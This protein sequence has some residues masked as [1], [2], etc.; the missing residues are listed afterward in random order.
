MCII[1][2]LRANDLLEEARAARGTRTK[3]IAYPSD[4]A[5]NSVGLRVLSY[6]SRPAALG[7]CGQERL[8]SGD[9]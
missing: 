8:R 7:Q 9:S 6:M 3:K 2:R 1:G 5:D 4:F